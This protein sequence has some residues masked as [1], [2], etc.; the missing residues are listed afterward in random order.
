[1]VVVVKTRILIKRYEIDQAI[2]ERI[3]QAAETNIAH[4]EEETKFLIQVIEKLESECEAR[5]WR[6]PWDFSDVTP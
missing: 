4:H 6:M 5:R 1:L 3:V 2:R